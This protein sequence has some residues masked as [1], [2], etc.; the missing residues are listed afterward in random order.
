LTANGGSS[1][2]LVGDKT[3]AGTE[4]RITLSRLGEI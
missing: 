4:I 1:W 3:F 2:D